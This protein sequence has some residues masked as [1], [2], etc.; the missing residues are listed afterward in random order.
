MT[1]QEAHAE[2]MAAAHRLG[3]LSRDRDLGPW[4]EYLRRYFTWVEL[5]RGRW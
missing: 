5:T 3:R 4:R 1:E 2:M